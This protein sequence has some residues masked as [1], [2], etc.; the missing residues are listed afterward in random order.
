MSDWDRYGKENDAREAVYDSDYYGTESDSGLRGRARHG[1]EQMGQSAQEVGGK[2]R[3]GFD[4]Y[5]HRHPLI[6]GAGAL[7]LGVAVG[8]MLPSTRQEDRWLGEASDRMKERTRE[9]AGKVGDVAKT[10]FKEARDTAQSEMEQRHM[11]PESLREGA[12]DVAQDAREVA[13]KTAQEARRAAE[14][15]AERN[16]LR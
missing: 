16:K 4:R 11:D 5:F 13:E 7:A 14:E 12:Q 1:M 10:S 9:A 8:M 3:R 15:E 2:A 6:V